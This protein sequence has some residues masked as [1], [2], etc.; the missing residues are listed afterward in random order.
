MKLV[1]ANNKGIGLVGQ[2]IDEYSLEVVQAY[3]THIQTSAELA[4][5]DMLREISESRGLADVDTLSA[6]DFMDDGS[7][8]RLSVTIDRRSGNGATAEFDFSGTGAQVFGNTNAPAAITYSA[9]IYC[10]RCL[11]KQSIPLNQGCLNPIT[12]HIPE[13]SLLKPSRDAAVVGGNVLT[14]QRI[15]DV[16]FRA[17]RACAASQGCMNNFTFGNDE[18][19]YY[20]TIAGGH[21]AG[22]SWHGKSGVHTHMTNTRITDPEV[23]ERRYP[24]HLRRFCLRPGTG[25]AGRFRGGHGVVR[26]VEFLVPLTVGILSERRVFRPY[27]LEGGEPGA[28]GRN[29]IIRASDGVKINLGPRNTYN[30]QPGDR[31]VIET[32]GGG[33]YGSPDDNPDDDD[34]A[35]AS[36]AR[37]PTVALKTGGSL[38]KY[39][40][41]QESA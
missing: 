7:P 27:G 6:E 33:G 24:V 37:L 14:S 20:E 17:F 28:V 29:H 36:S 38:G 30:A 26:E 8:I 16:V 10:M 31:I 1:A 40:L 9:I 18:F 35:A 39:S 25:G 5:R 11:V 4:V 23:L 41:S 2:L 19:G 15:T 21:G 12:V 22:P 34:A 3:M 13:G 32:P